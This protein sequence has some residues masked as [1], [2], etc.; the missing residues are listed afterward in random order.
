MHGDDEHYTL[1]VALRKHAVTWARG[2]RVSLRSRRYSPR[3]RPRE[4]LP[5]RARGPRKAD[6]RARA[7]AWADGSSWNSVT[8]RLQSDGYTVDV[9]PNPLRGVSS[10]S[11]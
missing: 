4:Q 11:T 6:H 8:T 3:H 7:R 2:S 9:P 5:R 10:D 1:T